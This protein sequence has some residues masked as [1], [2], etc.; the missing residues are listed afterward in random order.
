MEADFRKIRIE[1][2]EH[3]RKMGVDP[4]PARFDRT[5]TS[6]EALKLKL[7]AK[8]VRV[9]GRL[10]LIRDL[11]RICFAHIQDGAGRIQI[12]FN[13]KE[14]GKEQYKFFIKNFDLGDFIG[15]EGETFKTKAGEKTILVKKFEILTKSLLPLPDKW[16]GLQD[17]EERYRRRYLDLIMNPDVKKVFET[18]AK[19]LELTRGYLTKD[20]YTEVDVPALQ[21]VYGGAEAYPFVT[22][23]RAL[24]MKLYL[25]ISPELYLKKLLVGGFDKIFTISK[26]FRNEGIDKWHNPEF[27]MME[28]YSAYMDYNDMMKL[29]EGLLPFLAKKIRGT[30][31]IVYGEKKIDF[32]AP[33]KKYTIYDAIKKYAGIDVAKLSDVALKKIIKKNKLESGARAK[34]IMNI[35]D[36]LVQPQLIQPTFILDY[37]IEVSPL[38]KEHRKDKSLV[39]R[40]ELFIGGTELA[41]AYS[42]LNNPLEQEKRLT[43]QVAE[44]KK[45]KDFDPHFETNKIDADFL[46]AIEQGM[47]PAGGIGMG[48]DRLVMFLTGSESIRDVILFPFMRPRDN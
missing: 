5:H 20:G 47:P 40:F 33:F 38:T 36:E 39:E 41:N 24:D 14:I 31:T 46:E 16:H 4:Y 21:P 29:A 35:F 48:I 45:A 26:N 23:L 28:I 17:K 19:I 10:M 25:S 11:G 2:M 42:E 22:K 43:E 18:R 7:G 1:K 13:E 9:A 32:K 37:P 30:T 44:R 27:L 15:V 3:L 6:A 8:K 34:M 12:A